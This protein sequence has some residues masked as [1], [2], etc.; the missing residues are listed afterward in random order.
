VGNVSARSRLTFVPLYLAASAAFTYL[1]F[2]LLAYSRYPAAFGPWNNNWLSDLGNRVL[3]PDGAT[4]YVIGCTVSGA[5]LLGFF[6]TLVVWRSSGSRLRNWLL[7]LTQLAG[8]VAASSLIMSAVYTED[9][10]NEH[11]F[12]SRLIYAGF[13][14]VFFLSPFAL[15]RRGYGEWQLIMVAIVGY[16]AIVASL[17]FAD[18]HWLEWPAVAAI[19]VYVCLVGTMRESRIAR[20]PSGSFAGSRIDISG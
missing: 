5:L 10:F 20:A 4:F 13:A 9:L 14:L 3:N 18:A 7:V 15:H 6:A 16:A 17:I 2:S 12:W 1:A 8:A 19:L 11:Q